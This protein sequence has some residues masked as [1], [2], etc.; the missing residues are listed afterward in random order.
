ML[1]E[2]P[3]KAPNE[4]LEALLDS[5][6]KHAATGDLKKHG[7]KFTDDISLVILKKE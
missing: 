2:N 7:G 3:D 5:L 1:L 4:L 6:R